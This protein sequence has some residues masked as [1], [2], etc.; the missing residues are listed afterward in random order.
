MIARLELYFSNMTAFTLFTKQMIET[1]LASTSN[2]L[3]AE[4]LLAA[5]FSFSA[6]FQTSPLKRYTANGSEDRSSSYFAAIASKRI[7]Q[8]LDE[9]GDSSATL[10]LLQAYILLTFYELTRAVRSR[11]WRALGQSIRI[12]YELKLHLIDQDFKCAAKATAEGFNVDV[13]EWARREEKRRAWWAIWE[14][15]V[16]ASTIRRLPT[17]IDWAQ[18]STLLPVSDIK[19]LEKRPGTSCFL[20]LDPTLRWKSLVESQNRSAKAWFILVNSL[21]RN[22]QV[23]V[24]SPGATQATYTAEDREVDLLSLSNALYCTV[25]SLPEELAYHGEML[26]F[27][28]SDA[29]DEHSV[30]LQRQSD[31]Y[32]LHLMTQLSHF[33]VN[34]HQIRAQA[35]WFHGTVEAAAFQPAETYHKASNA[36]WSNYMNAADEIVAV[37]RN[38]ATH[39]YRHVN[40]FLTNTLWFAAAAQCSCRVFGPPSLSKQRRLADSNLELLRL[41]ID[42]FIDFWGSTESLKDKL[43]RMESGLK[44]LMEQRRSRN[45]VEDRER[46]VSAAPVADSAMAG[47]IPSDNMNSVT[48]MNDFVSTLAPNNDLFAFDD[49]LDQFPYGLDDLLMPYNNSNLINLD[50]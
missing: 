3:D 27:R 47:T 32:S 37:V 39:H 33:M 34:H 42:R 44:S 14:M 31:K 45:N 40:P 26:T 10:C 12:A 20:H 38:S 48:G 28:A 9:Y 50:L 6:R 49:P 4:A 25:S 22:T 43:A 7:S 36:E 46:P 16:F 19:W 35:P 24:Y 5:M 11:A 21:M 41:T 13:E 15:D 18:N 29:A 23:I 8:G 1:K 30:Q 2:I 17:A